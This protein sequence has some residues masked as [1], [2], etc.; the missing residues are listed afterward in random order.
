MSSTIALLGGDEFSAVYETLD[1]RL[2]ALAGTADV[3]VIP[4]A[5]AFEH[6]QR[7]VDAAKWWFASLGAV[8]E[9]LM[10]LTRS[11][12]NDQGNAA[13]VASSRFVY[14]VGDSPLHLRAVMKD[15]PTWSAIKSVVDGGGVLAASTGAAA[16]LCDPM[17]DPRGGAFTIGLGLISGLALIA[18]AETWTP[19]RHKRS[20]ELASGFPIA[21]VPSGAALLRIGN[22]WEMIGDVV[23]DGTLPA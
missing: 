19:E 1:R 10:V 21:E 14:L 13:R 6:P 18:R 9:G 8:A 4:T 23:I 20:V 22:G 15:T 11:D 5:D 12:A 2:L 16:A 7:L 3:L 17:V